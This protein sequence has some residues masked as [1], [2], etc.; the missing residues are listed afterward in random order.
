MALNDF[1]QTTQMHVDPA[2]I[3]LGVGQPQAS[4]LPLDLIRQAAER[5]FALNDTSFLQ[6]G[7]EQGDGY[8]RAQLAKLLTREYDFGVGPENLFITNGASLGLDLVCTLFTKPGD[9]IFVE[10]PS[11]FLALRIFADHHL[12][13]VPIPMDENGLIVEA[14]EDELKKVR[15]A[16]LYTIPTFQNP[17]GY[18]L[19]E[20]RRERLALLSREYNFLIVADEVYHL[21]NYSAK[22]PKAFAGYTEEGNIISLG[23]FSKILAPGLRLGWIQT[24]PERAKTFA[25]CGLV[26]SGGGLNPFTS[27]I[28]RGM[29]E[30]NSL[31]EHIQH[32]CS[33][34]RAR[35]AAMDA[36]LQEYLPEVVY[37]VPQ[38]GYFFWIRFPN[39]R[40]AELLMPRA[41]EL[42]V[43]FRPGVRFSSRGALG[44]FA[45]LCFAYYEAEQL[46]EGI[47]RI[48]RALE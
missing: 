5:R 47:E 18:T 1:V 21:L 45:R 36:V 11:Y 3:D 39:G 8:L 40:D 44:D 23:S 31:K 43:S 6:Y 19:S 30:T 16:F 10:E 41:E 42:K 17:S 13:P 29:L 9:T 34:Y 28:V 27:A 26:D 46:T 32:L 7:A 37:Q 15:P 35:V 2:V 25:V 4:L 14:L 48:K 38:G 12:R 24:D 22:L 20:A 33:V